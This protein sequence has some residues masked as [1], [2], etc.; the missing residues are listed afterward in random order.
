MTSDVERDEQRCA[1]G[2]EEV[3]R[4]RRNGADRDDLRRP[5]RQPALHVF[6]HPIPAEPGCPGPGFAHGWALSCTTHASRHDLTLPF[7]TMTAQHAQRQGRL[8]GI[9]SMGA[10]PLPAPG[11]RVRGRPEWRRRSWAIRSTCRSPVRSRRRSPAGTT[12]LR[13]RPGGCGSPL[14]AGRR[15]GRVSARPVR[16]PVRSRGSARDADRDR[17]AT[18]RGGR[19]PVDLAGR[20]RVG[21]SATPGRS[22]WPG[23]GGT[24]E[25]SR[26]PAS[27]KAKAD[28]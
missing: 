15:A 21:R 10:Q 24:V 20:P 17:L 11:P 13:C 9:A 12:W 22:A 14:T 8:G 23:R 19:E 2:P 3:A 16:L 18:P 27:G 6:R 7:T 5:R 1:P 28:R 25:G 26:P 4:P